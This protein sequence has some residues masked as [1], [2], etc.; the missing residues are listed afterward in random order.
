MNIEGKENEENLFYYYFNGKKVI[1]LHL[2]FVCIN[3]CHHKYQQ[4]GGN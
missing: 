1:G 2:R 4:V 3:V